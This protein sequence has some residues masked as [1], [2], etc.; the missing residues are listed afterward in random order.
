MSADFFHE[1]EESQSH[2]SND[3]TKVSKGTKN[4]GSVLPQWVSS[5]LLP[6]GAS[7]AAGA[8]VKCWLVSR[9]PQTFHLELYWQGAL[10]ISL[11]L[12]TF[13]KKGN[14]PWNYDLNIALDTVLLKT[15]ISLS[16]I[17][18]KNIFPNPSLSMFYDLL[19]IF[20]VFGVSVT[21]KQEA[22]G[23]VYL[24]FLCNIF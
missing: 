22:Y 18:D 20:P 11:F 19:P 2:R 5:S 21:L 4:S 1:Y 7:S 17:G 23:Y 15:S 14:Y 13:L 10:T 3:R 24:L 6:E 8:G 9:P 12:A 16:Q